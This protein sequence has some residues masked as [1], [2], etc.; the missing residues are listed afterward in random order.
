[1]HSC[2]ISKNVKWCH[3]IW[4]TLYS[5][6]HGNGLPV[7]PTADQAGCPYNS[8]IIINHDN[9]DTLGL[10]TEKITDKETDTNRDRTVFGAIN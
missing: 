5:N 2:V 1:M 9:K 6:N 8:F 3:L 10:L 7:K 4:P